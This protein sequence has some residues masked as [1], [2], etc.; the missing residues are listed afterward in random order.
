MRGQDGTSDLIAGACFSEFRRIALPDGV[1]LFTS[2]LSG[3]GKTFVCTRL[4]IAHALKR[5]RQK[6]LL[7]I[8]LNSLSA[9][10]TENLLPRDQDQAS[11]IVDI[12]SR[13]VRLKNCI[14][15]SII[16]GL[17]VLPYGQP[18]QDFEPLQHLRTLKQ[19]IDRLR[20]H[21]IILIDTCASFTRN[22]RNFD[23]A[24]I[25]PIADHVYF[26]L[27]AGK[28]PREVV[29]RCTKEFESCGGHVAGIIM[30]DRFVRPLRS[31]VS[32][33]LSCLEKIPLIRIPLRYIRHRLGIY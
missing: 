26:I 32:T 14:Y 25:S 1:S 10:G 23:P 30:N 21:F 17:F 11:G 9:Q 8:N 19:M 6:P 29:M 18:S 24:E 12:F 3:E 13:K 33:Y 15:P 5:G 2:A 20:Q 16:P 4:A 22:R 28:T 7:L 31:E 27:L